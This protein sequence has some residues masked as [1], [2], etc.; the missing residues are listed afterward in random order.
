MVRAPVARLLVGRMVSFPAEDRLIEH[1]PGF[2]ALDNSG[3]ILD[4]GPWDARARRRW[5]GRPRTRFARALLMPGFV[6]A[7][8]HLPQ[9]HMRGVYGADLL[10]WLRDYILPAEAQFASPTIARRT[11]REFFAELLRNGTTCAMVYSSV[12][13][14]ATDI[15]FEE[16]DRAGIRAIIGKVMMDRNVPDDLR[17][18]TDRSLSESLALFRR[19]QGFDANRLQYTFAPRFAPSCSV[20][21]MQAT[22]RLA[23]R[24]NAHVTTHLAET[25]AELSL[26]RRMFPGYSRYT[27]LYHQM[28]LLGTRT[29]AA[30]CIHLDAQEYQRL[31]NTGT[32]VAHCP[33]ANLF[34]HAG[35]MDLRRMEKE[36]ITVGLGTDVGAGP[37]FSLFAVMQ[38]MYY[39]HKS[40]PGKAFFRATLGGATALGLER[41]IGSLEPGKEADFIVVSYPRFQA[42]EPSIDELLSQ[43][44][45]RGDDR[46]IKASYVRGKCVYRG[47][48]PVAGD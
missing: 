26:T 23:A 33:S 6:D 29:V 7:H 42:A 16:A 44:M 15:A 18:R 46:L 24:L 1:N 39:L 41:S 4:F 19:W 20:R 36:R 30:H 32:R 34:L 40:A 47:Q 25:R 10:Q 14:R 22:G 37:S 5:P 11:A 31:S 43:L 2:L 35:S 48:R 38:N 28:G 21:L 3:M 13:A 12:H 9:M 17:E 8:L 45:F 27:E